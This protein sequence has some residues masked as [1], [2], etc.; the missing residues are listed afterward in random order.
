ECTVQAATEDMIIIVSRLL[1]WFTKRFVESP[2]DMNPEI[3]VHC[4]MSDEGSVLVFEVRS[5]RLGELLRK[6]LFEPFTQAVPVPLSSTKMNHA[7]IYLPLYLAKMLVEEKYK[8]RL[9]ECSNEIEG[10]LGHRFVVRFQPPQS[11]SK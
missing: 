1:Q 3:S 6:R 5:R 11:A 4:T 9:E 7:G 8:G 10:G 2:S